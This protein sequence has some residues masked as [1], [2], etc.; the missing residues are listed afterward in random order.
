MFSFD[1]H[2]FYLG[3]QSRK[4]GK[5]QSVYTKALKDWLVTISS[6]CDGI[7]LAIQVDSEILLAICHAQHPTLKQA[8]KSVFVRSMKRLLCS[9]ANKTQMIKAAYENTV[10]VKIDAENK[11]KRQ[12]YFIFS[13]INNS[14]KICN[15][16]VVSDINDH[17]IY[18]ITQLTNVVT[19][20]S[21]NNSDNFPISIDTSNPTNTPTP[22]PTILSLTSTV[23]TLLPISIITSKESYPLLHPLIINPSFANE[24][25]KQRIEQL[26]SELVLLH[27]NQRRKTDFRYSNSKAAMLIAVPGAKTY[28]TYEKN[29]R[30]EK[31]L[32]SIMKFIGKTGKNNCTSTVYSWLLKDTYKHHPQTFMKV[33]IDA[34]IH[35]VHKMTAVDAAAMWVDANISF[36]AARTIIRH[37]TKTFKH[38]IQVPFSQ[39]QLLG[40]VTN[41]IEPA[42]DKFIF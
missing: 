38:H 1:C 31:W 23:D 10:Y 39:I 8:S 4:M 29:K 27:K 30:R 25:D 18:F 33:C 42:F 41:A 5:T 11:T 12:N 15:P 14:D 26:L 22:T 28:S 7:K 32:E 9:N 36:N 40:N 3:P 6:N 34:G 2:F 35:I 19:S 13:D 21:Q 17:R 20:P 37:L 24:T 16:V